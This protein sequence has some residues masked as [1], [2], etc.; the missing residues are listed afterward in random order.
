MRDFGKGFEIVIALALVGFVATLG[1]F[2]FLT[3]HLLR[4]LMFYVGAM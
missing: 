4:A 3:W 1:A 2:G